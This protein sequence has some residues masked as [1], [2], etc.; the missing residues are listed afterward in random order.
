MKEIL[1]GRNHTLNFDRGSQ[2]TSSSLIA[3]TL[4]HEGR[5]SESNQ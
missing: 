1:L 3:R 4:D 2:K 5:G